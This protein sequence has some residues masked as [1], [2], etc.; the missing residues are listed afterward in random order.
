MGLLQH[1]DTP[2]HHSPAHTDHLGFRLCYLFHLPGDADVRHRALIRSELACSGHLE[3]RVRVLAARVGTGASGEEG[4]LTRLQGRVWDV[5]GE[6]VAGQRR[7]FGGVGCG[8][9]VVREGWSGIGKICW[10]KISWIFQ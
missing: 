9:G 6:G 5:E 4:V 3:A 7:H 1:H 8:G 2:L 10:E